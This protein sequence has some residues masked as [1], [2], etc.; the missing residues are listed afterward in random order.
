MHNTVADMSYE[1][2][3][4][5]AEEIP[6]AFSSYLFNE[7]YHVT[8]QPCTKVFTFYLFHTKKKQADAR[9]N[10]FVH[11]N[12]GI[13]PCLGT[14]GSVEMNENLPQSELDIFIDSIN[15]F[16][17]QHK[18]QAISIKAYPF[19]Y[20]EEISAR[21]TAAFTH[22]SYQ[23]SQT[24]LNYHLPVTEEPFTKELHLSARRRLKKCHQQGFVFS[25]ELQP[26][27]PEIYWMIQATRERRG[28]PVT[29]DYESFEQLFVRFPEVY[30]IF[31]VKDKYKT[32]AL[33]ITV[34]INSSILYYFLPADDPDYRSSS[35]MIMLI[36][37]VYTYCQQ[38]QFRIFDL[39]IA[40][41]KG[42]PNYGL[43]RFK[44]NLGS[45]SSLKFTFTRNFAS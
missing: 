22:N 9:F 15:T 4:N 45:K 5:P 30:R 12:T 7:P 6:C 34:Q 24:E 41:Y 1:I 43:I 28:F 44:Q 23:I 35:P 11:E 37:G 20:A 27:L 18:L 36:E 16:A 10:L 19:C 26:N 25:E 29:L 2:L 13:S 40:T 8:Q 42:V 31:T 21:I 17:F 38:Q 32:I 3:I 14:F 33:T 39:G